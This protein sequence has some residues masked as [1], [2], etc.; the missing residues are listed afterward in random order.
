MTKW[1]DPVSCPASETLSQKPPPQPTS[2]VL[3][4]AS[5]PSAPAMPRRLARSSPLPE[6]PGRPAQP[7]V[8]PEIL[9]RVLDGLRRL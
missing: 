9:R 7:P 6:T 1:Q 3:P 4:A 5:E 8:G 2:A